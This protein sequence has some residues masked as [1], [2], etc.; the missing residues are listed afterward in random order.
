MDLMGASSRKW[1]ARQVSESRFI[2]R[3]PDAQKVKELSYFPA[4]TMGTVNAQ[5]KIVPWSPNLGAKGE[6]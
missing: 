1:I 3:F 4:L 2:M 6:L 5:M